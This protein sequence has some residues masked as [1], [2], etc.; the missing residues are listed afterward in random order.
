MVRK[1]RFFNHFLISFFILQL[2]LDDAKMKN[3]TSCFKDRKF[4][5]FFFQRV[6]FNDT[7]RYPE[8]KYISVCGRELNYIRVEADDVPIVFTHV[9][10]INKQDGV[11]LLSCNHTGNLLTYKF[12]PDKIYMAPSG[13]V[14][15]P[16]QEK[17]G[18]IGLV[19]SKLAIEFSKFFDFRD[20]ESSAP[21]HFTWRGFTHQLDSDWVAKTHRK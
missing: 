6:K 12:Q 18:A 3:F 19:R 14:Y 21:T 7:P 15:H 1:N 2:F 5:Q 8:F 10:P 16:A 4:L 11:E 13:R 17:Y 20:D 9:L